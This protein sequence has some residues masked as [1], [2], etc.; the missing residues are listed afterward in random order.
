[1]AAA[2][3]T[4]N[5]KGNDNGVSDDGNVKRCLVR[6]V[7]FLIAVVVALPAALA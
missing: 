2:P 5:G 6:V 1:M 3:P 4:G 7:S